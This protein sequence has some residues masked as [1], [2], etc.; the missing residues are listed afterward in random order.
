MSREGNETYISLKVATRLVVLL[1]CHQ[2]SIL[3]VC[4]RVR[5]QGDVII[6]SDCN[7]AILK[8]LNHLEVALDLIVGGEGMDA[9]EAIEGN[10]KHFN[11]RV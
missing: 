11:S 10:W 5:L 7:K 4:S 6:L 2:A 9:T 3:T 8:L 1:D